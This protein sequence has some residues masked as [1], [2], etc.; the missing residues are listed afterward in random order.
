MAFDKDF[1]IGIIPILFLGVALI[2]FLT[3]IDVVI[4]PVQNHCK[5]C[6]LNKNQTCNKRDYFFLKGLLAITLLTLALILDHI[7]KVYG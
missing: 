4:S 5:S 3:I 1:F 2:S 7:S 6:P